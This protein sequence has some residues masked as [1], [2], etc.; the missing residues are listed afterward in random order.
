MRDILN[1]VLAFIGATSLTDLEYAGLPIENSSDDVANYNALLGVLDSRESV[2][3]LPQRLQFYYE[4]KGVAVIAPQTGKSN[5]LI[6]F[7][8]C[9]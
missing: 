4:A 2:S 1:A 6:G 8:L 9:E 5:I 7:P 3:N